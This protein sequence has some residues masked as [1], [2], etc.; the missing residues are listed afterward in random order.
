MKKWITGLLVLFMN[1]VSANLPSGFVYVEEVDPTIIQSLRY[2]TNE[3][4]IGEVM[5]GYKKPKLILTK[6]AATALSK[7]Q[8]EFLA[9]GYSLVIYDAYRPQKAVDNFVRWGKDIRDVSMKERYY[10]RVNKEEIFELGYVA[11]KSSHS[12]GST[13]DLSIIPVKNQLKTL[14]KIIYSERKLSDGFT[15]P[16]LDDGTIDMGSSFDLFDL[17]SHQ[18]SPLVTGEFAK[19]RN[20]LREK[21][22]KHGFVEYPQEWWHFTLKAEPYPETYFNFDIE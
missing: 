7:V 4:F 18:D 14:D 17:V 10:P 5:P 11:E 16:F 1:T 13:V 9:E 15:I 19:R 20:Y 22:K 8:Q 3:N 6:E 12:R 21:M 2:V